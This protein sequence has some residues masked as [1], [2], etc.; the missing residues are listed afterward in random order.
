MRDKM[1][2]V[3]G[4]VAINFFSFGNG[5]ALTQKNRTRFDASTCR[6]Y[7]SVSARRSL[8]PYRLFKLVSSRLQFLCVYRLS[9][10]CQLAE[11]LWTD[12]GLKSGIGVRELIGT[13]KKGV[14]GG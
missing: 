4:K 1:I 11:P 5:Q 12:P 7:I 9:Q 14:G 6:H 8:R 2:I 13:F 3:T 10:S